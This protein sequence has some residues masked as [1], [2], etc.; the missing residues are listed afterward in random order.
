MYSNVKSVPSLL[1]FFVSN[2][3]KHDK[4][5]QHVVHPNN[6]IFFQILWYRGF[7]V[8]KPNRHHSTPWYF[9]HVVKLKKHS[10]IFY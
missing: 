6:S 3:S 9:K 7:M 8:Y 5:G 2:L 1:T 10:H 4:Y